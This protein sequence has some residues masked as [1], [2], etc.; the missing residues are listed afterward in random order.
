MSFSAMYLRLGLLTALGAFALS[1]PAKKIK[2]TNA[3]KAAQLTA[4][5]KGIN[6]EVEVWFVNVHGATNREKC[7]NA[8]F[9]NMGIKGHKQ[10]AMQ[11]L[12]PDCT[13]GGEKRAFMTDYDEAT[14]VLKNDEN[15]RFHIIS[16]WCTHKQLFSK[17]YNGT[18]KADFF[19]VMEDDTVMDEE[20]FM[21]LMKTFINEYDGQFKDNWQMVQL[22]FYGSSCKAHRVGAVG[23]K[24]VFKPAN[25]FKQGVNFKKPLKGSMECAQYFGGQAYLIRKSEI[26]SIVENMETHQTVPLDWLAAQLPRGLAWK[27][28]IAFNSR[29]YKT[30]KGYAKA[31]GGAHFESNIAQAS[32]NQK[33]KK[34]KSA[35]LELNSG[36]NRG[37]DEEE[38]ADMVL[39]T[40]ESINAPGPG[41]EEVE[42]AAHDPASILQQYPRAP[43]TV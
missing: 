18:S 34:S 38:M 10:I 29:S 24:T 8:Q 14:K 39:S 4:K 30:T 17:L 15:T 41:D 1:K 32:N 37:H 11:K 19:M 25:L 13:A 27:P 35:F 5:D 26:P 40:V 20:K 23:G 6:D 22:D 33:I 3:T 7:M 31:C 16:N 28:G 9:E 42:V 36:N 2:L 12:T 21:P 43:V